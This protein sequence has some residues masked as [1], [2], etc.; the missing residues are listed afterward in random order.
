MSQRQAEAALRPTL[1]SRTVY[2]SNDSICNHRG[3]RDDTEQ[4]FQY[5]QYFGHFAIISIFFNILRVVGIFFGFSIGIL[6]QMVK[7]QQN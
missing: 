4:Y 2:R 3:G 1:Q 7:I 6:I 5:F